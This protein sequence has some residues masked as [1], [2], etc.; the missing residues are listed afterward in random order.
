MSNRD[1]V[2]FASIDI[3]PYVPSVEQGAIKQLEFFW[4]RAFCAEVNQSP[5]LR[6]NFSAV[7]QNRFCVMGKIMNELSLNL[8]QPPSKLTANPLIID[9]D[10][11]ENPAPKLTEDEEVLPGNLIAGSIEQGKTLLNEHKGKLAIGVAATLG[12]MVFYKWREKKLA[13]EDPEEYA[14]LQRIKAVVRE[15]EANGYPAARLL[16][17]DK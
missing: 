11:P 9:P 13:E 15:E 8:M 17:E 10:M 6:T 4:A 7:Q 12:L 14:R 2:G 3:I 1:H 5:N 16:D